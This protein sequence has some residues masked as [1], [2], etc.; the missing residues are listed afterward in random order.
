[1]R[2]LRGRLLVGSVLGTI[3]VLV[4]AGG[5]LYTMVARTLRT[6]F[7][8]A[9]AA[10]A[11]SLTALVEQDEDGLESELAAAS[12]PQFEP[13][14]RAEFYQAW[15]QDGTVIARSP[16]LG[17]GNLTR[18]SGVCDEPSFGT[19]ALPDGR[20]GRVVWL[21]FV[22]RQEGRQAAAARP[23]GV[24]LAL[25][26]DT[27]GLRATLAR[28]RDILIAVG[29]VAVL[30]LAGVLTWAIRSGLRPVDELGRQIAEVGAAG[31]SARIGPGGMPR[32][33]SPV[34]DRLNDLLARLEAAFQ[35]ERRFTGN[36]AHELRTPLAG[37]RS[38]LEVC[39]SRERTPEAY[40]KAMVDCLAIDLQ[41]QRMVENLLHLA[42]A[43]AGQLGVRSEPT[44]VSGMVRECW[45]LL[46]DKAEARGLRIEWL[47]DEP[48]MVASDAEK[49]RLVVQNLLD[50]A[51]THGSRGGRVLVSL[52]SVEGELV[53]AVSNTARELRAADVPRMFDRFW[54]GDASHGRAEE[55]HCGLGLPLCRSVVERLGGSVEA[56]LNDDRLF[57]ITVRLPN[58]TPGAGSKQSAESLD[59]V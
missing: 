35:R 25:A 55:G 58:D 48:G 34:V 36:V 19:V 53:L 8:E 26:R 46:G 21:S 7:D 10:R 23:V 1:M 30:L 50:N 56:V 5:V 20:P 49:L 38:K 11:R 39:L 28:V 13:S 17:D 40:R 59:S 2:S 57:T 31:L 37:L 54:R 52:A 6:G 29:V 41:V 4:V 47:V 24:T 15:M 32:E 14:D 22:P 9:L 45:A 3:A 43:D 27:L 42:R 44:D 51:V 12:L 33:L 16:S 18:V